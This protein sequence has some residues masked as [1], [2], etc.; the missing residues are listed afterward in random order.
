VNNL[1]YTVS[2]KYRSQE[3]IERDYPKFLEAYRNGQ[4][5][6]YVVDQIREVMEQLGD[7]PLIVRSSSL[8][9]DNFG[10]AFAGKYDSFFLPNQGTPEENLSDL[11]RA[12]AKV[13]ASVLNP[14]AL[15]YRQIQRLEDY[16]ERMAILIQR[17]EGA[18][19]GNYF[20]P[21]MAG[22]GFSRNP[23]IWN[24]KLKAEEGFLRLVFGLG[25]RA[26]DRVD[27]DYPR[28]IGLSHPTLRPVT[29]ATDIR[30]YSQNSVDVI[31]LEE[32]SLETVPATELLS[33]DFPG[34]QYI[35][36]VDEGEF[37]KPIFSLGSTIP[38]ENMVLTFD[39]LLKNTDFSQIMRTMLAKL[40]RHYRRP[41]DI[42]FTVQIEPDYPKPNIIVHLLQCR[43]LSNQQWTP[44]VV[45]PQNIRLSDQLF[46]V[47]H[48][49][50]QG[51]VERIKYIVYVD[52]VAYSKIPDN[53]IR[54]ELARVIGRLNKCLE[55]EKFVLMGPGRWGS[56]N[57]DL[58]IKVTYADIY[59][60]SMLIEI[61]V[62]DG[63]A[64][65]EVSYGTHFFQDLVESNIYPLSV[66]P[67][68][69]ASVFNWKFFQKTINQLPKLLPQDSPYADYIKVIDVPNASQ[70]RFLRV[71]MNAEENK[72]LGYFSAY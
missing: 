27:W 5:P 63:G 24:K 19:H 2:A 13:Y 15:F 4:F 22:V 31:N 62:A 60:T 25:T 10:S 43:P 11:L 47:D 52:P 36:S 57:I 67:N 18:R 35:A 70:N 9:E 58:G 54:L 7:C 29:S 33:S 72:A 26:V 12:I 16:D 48:I 66:F 61:A 49:V 38:P 44:D 69:A 42:E 41:V 23:Y 40:E 17:V 30:K 34:V 20:F 3:A 53:T 14:D 50:P 59:N 28:M 51:I 68:N 65:T 37:I 8:L 46:T 6:D 64:T 56:S 1:E 55:G 21:I 32:N 45:I 71:I 39:S